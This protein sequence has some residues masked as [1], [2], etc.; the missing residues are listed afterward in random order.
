M[1]K[2]SK[3]GYGGSDM[4]FRQLQAFAEVAETRSFSEAAHR[5]YLSQPTVSGHIKALEKELGTLLFRRTTK[6]VV[7]TPEGTRFLPYALRMIEL[8]R[9]GEHSLETKEKPVLRL[10]AS[11]FPSAF[12]LPELLSG[13][14]EACPDVRFIIRQNDSA[15]IEEMVADHVAEVGFTGRICQ[16]NRIIC[17]P[18]CRDT[19]VLAA[20]ADSVF[21]RL[22]DQGVPV[23]QVILRNRFIAREEGSATRQA[24]FRLLEEIGIREEELDILVSTNDLESVRQMIVQGLGISI[25][26]ERAVRSL[27]TD[28]K[29]ILFSLPEGWGREFYMIVPD[30]YTDKPVLEEF[31]R[32][33][34]KYFDKS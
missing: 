34:R 1:I 30:T 10:G 31:V 25:L 2:S 26:S 23:R 28:G 27:E 11:T 20:P 32:F 14:H 21:R 24:S 7:L 8:K 12:I 22:K 5:M 16:D 6:K 17:H 33:V 9:A 4:D 29:A 19:L 18:L 13:F 15:H 3:T